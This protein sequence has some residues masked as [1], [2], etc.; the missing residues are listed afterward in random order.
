MS[1]MT[2]DSGTGSP[3]SAVVYTVPAGMI[4]RICAASLLGLT[5]PYFSRGWFHMTLNGIQ[6]ALCDGLDVVDLN[7]GR[8][9]SA[10]VV[11]EGT[12]IGATCAG[13]DSGTDFRAA[14]YFIEVPVGTVFYV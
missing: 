7:E 13:G 9:L 10:Q 1:V 2:V 14:L 3:V 5:S 4:A 8:V 11:P 12:I 6:V